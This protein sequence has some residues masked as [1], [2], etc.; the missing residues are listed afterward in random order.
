MRI[1]TY[2]HDVYLTPEGELLVLIGLAGEPFNNSEVWV[3]ADGL[4]TFWSR[5]S[6]QDRKL[7]YLG[8]L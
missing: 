3:Y 5:L 2:N 6:P 8:K 7:E 4:A 1:E